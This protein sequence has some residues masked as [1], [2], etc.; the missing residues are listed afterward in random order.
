MMTTLDVREG[1]P[2]GVL[3]RLLFD[4]A[5]ACFATLRQRY[6]TPLMLPA[7]RCHLI[8]DYAIAALFVTLFAAIFAADDVAA[9]P[10]RL[11]C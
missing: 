7:L 10:L 3:L 5:S 2:R 1:M 6:F 8:A 11:C 4:F 9:M